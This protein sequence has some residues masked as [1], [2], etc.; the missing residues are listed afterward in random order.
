MRATFYPDDLTNDV[1]SFDVK[2][3][4]ADCTLGVEKAFDG[5]I[6][7]RGSFDGDVESCM[8]NLW[9]FYPLFCGLYAEAFFKRTEYSP[10]PV[11]RLDMS[12]TIADQ[13]ME[14][15]NDSMVLQVKRCA[16]AHSVGISD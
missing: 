2:F 11:I 12:E 8:Q 16:N 13:G 10:Y 7:R 4:N 15:L 6:Y 14:I 5:Q 1:Y 3:P 9:R